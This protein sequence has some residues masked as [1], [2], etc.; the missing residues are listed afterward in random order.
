MGEET[1]KVLTTSSKQVLPATRFPCLMFFDDSRRNL[2]GKADFVYGFVIKASVYDAKFSKPASLSEKAQIMWD[3][4]NFHK[5]YDANAGITIKAIRAL[6]DLLPNSKIDC[7]VFDWDLTLSQHRALISDAIHSNTK[8]A[9]ECFFGGKDRMSAIKEFFRF[10]YWK[11]IRVR[12]VTSNPIANHNPDMI[13]KILATVYASWV[14]IIYSRQKMKYVKENST[15][16]M[17]SLCNN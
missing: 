10:A 11:H 9:A 3:A 15:M 2:T 6:K 13:K 14:P 16:F 5:T 7:V 4:H 8:V 12:I 17:K 1:F